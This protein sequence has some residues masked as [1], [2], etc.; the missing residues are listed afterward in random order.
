[1]QELTIKDSSGNT[2]ALDNQGNLTQLSLSDGSLQNFFADASKVAGLN[3]LASGVGTVTFT[4][5]DSKYAFD[6]WK[7]FYAQASTILTGQYEKLSG[8]S[9]D[10]YVPQKAIGAGESDIVGLNIDLPDNMDEDSLIFATGKGTR[11]IWDPKDYTLNLIGG[12]AA[13]AQEV[14]AL[15]PKP[16]GGYYSLGKLLVSAYEHQ[17]F[18][19][20]LVPVAAGDG[21]VP[22]VDRQRYEDSLNSIYNRIN[23]SWTVVQAAAFTSTGWDADRNGLLTMSGSS[24]LSN[25]LTGEPGALIK[26]Y[27]NAVP[28]DNTKKYVFILNTSSG[29]TGE[30]GG[31]QGDMPRA[32]QYGFIFLKANA[33]VNA[34]PAVTLAHELGHGQF[35]LEH[36]FSGDIALGGQGATTAW[37]NLMD[38]LGSNYRHLYKYQWNQAHQPGQVMGIFESDEAGQCVMD[39]IYSQ[40]VVDTARTP[41]GGIIYTPDLKEYKVKGALISPVIEVNGTLSRFTYN[42][43]TYISTYKVVGP[44]DQITST[45]TGYVDQDKVQALGKKT[46][47]ISDIVKNGCMFDPDAAGWQLVTKNSD[48]VDMMRG[49]FAAHNGYFQ[50]DNPQIRA[51]ILALVQKLPG[52]VF[53]INKDDNYVFL[54][55]LQKLKERLQGIMNVLTVGNQQLADLIKAYKTVKGTRVAKDLQLV[56]DETDPINQARCNISKLL[57][58]Q[59]HVHL[60]NSGVSDPEFANFQALTS[61]QRIDLLNIYYDAPELT[62]SA[63]GVTG[64]NCS[65]SF[66]GEQI[67]DAVLSYSTDLDKYAILNLFKQNPDMLRRFYLQIDNK[68]ILINDNNFDVFVHELIKLSAVA[69]QNVKKVSLVSTNPVI[70]W[71]DSLRFELVKYVSFTDDAKLQVSYVTYAPGAGTALVFFLPA[72]ALADMKIN[73]SPAVDPMQIVNLVIPRP[74]S[75]FPDLPQDP[76]QY[77]YTLQLPAIS[78]A[79]MVNKSTNDRIQLGVDLALIALPVG[80]LFEAGNGLIYLWRAAKIAV[81]A[82]DVLLK[83]EEG[84]RVL[85]KLYGIYDSGISDEERQARKQKANNFSDQYTKFSNLVNLGALGEGMYKMYTSL[86]GSVYDMRSAHSASYTTGEQQTLGQ[87][88]NDMNSFDA[89]LP[90]NLKKGELTAVAVSAGDNQLFK[91]IESVLGK[92]AGGARAAMDVRGNVVA[93]ILDNGSLQLD[94]VGTLEDITAGSKVLKMEEGQTFVVRGSTTP[95]TEDLMIVQQSD[96]SV[97][98]VRGACFAA[99]TRVLTANGLK[100]IEEIRA[101]EAVKSFD[102]VTR[103]SGLHKVVRIMQRTAGKMVILSAGSSTIRCTPEHPVYANHQWTAAGKLHIGDTLLTANGTVLLQGREEKD[104]VAVVYNLEVEGAHSYYV[105]EDKICVH[106]DCA[107]FQAVEKQLNDPT[108]YKEFHATYSDAANAPVLALFKKGTLSLN[109]WKCLRPYTVLVKDATILAQVEAVIR[110]GHIAVDDL[111]AII[112]ANRQ[113]GGAAAAISDLLRDLANLSNYTNCPGYGTL[114]SNLQKAD[115]G[116]ADGAN[117]IINALRKYPK[118]FKPANVSFEVADGIVRRYDVVTAAGTRTIYYEFKSYSSLPPANFATQFLNDLKNLNVNDLTIDIKWWFDSEKLTAAKISADDFRTQ[119][120][121]ALQN[122]DYDDATIRKFVTGRDNPGRQDLI[123]LINANFDNI[124]LIK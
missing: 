23:I 68:S 85:Y 80:E 7:P 60:I 74:S 112:A 50:N 116:S 34:D 99:G 90:D 47:Y 35:N 121:A 25:S 59:W 117:W 72:A 29:S 15:Y 28:T 94:A 10:Y 103:T 91:D 14:Y 54:L 43:R 79:W 105:G 107:Y 113:L 45:F 84:N 17:D 75:Y 118:Q 36:T 115:F 104:T 24:F 78:V 27:R 20:V 2:Y 42:N 93:E 122:L 53:T 38:Y 12:P 39:N 120:K 51:D 67:V 40:F 82:V 124:F 11:L 97:I 33:D 89:A 123:N 100:K 55:D 66:Y 44:N 56:I 87:I 88:E 37:P 83:T 57:N 76:N 111:A 49:F 92:N 8:G 114:I 26:A 1:M 109:S 3:T 64:Y 9:G 4:D 69:N 62:S 16:G 110:Q 13:D 98:C 46:W 71:S 77:P 65:L 96:Q 6:A 31:L 106:N 63:W 58:D 119:M 41:D 70:V 32:T 108:L 86:R 5:A 18:T 22:N 101:G 81:P 95:F 52:K 48:V 21:V 61:D 19:A 102:E 73:T 30:A